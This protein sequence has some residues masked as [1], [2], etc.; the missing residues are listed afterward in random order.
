M[1]QSVS[2]TGQSG[3]S[4]NYDVH[5]LPWRPAA[6]QDGNYIFAKIVNNV[7]QP[8]YI[9]QGNLQER[10]DAALGEGCV[11]SKGATHYHE[12]LNGLK[13]NR[14]NEEADL[15]AGHPNCKWPTGCNGKD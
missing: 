3:T 5:A 15:I 7:W 8:V 4:Y 9:G 2:W 12:H 11:R 10:Y 13:T 1:S 14:V 6:G